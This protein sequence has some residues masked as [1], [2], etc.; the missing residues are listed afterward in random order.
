MKKIGYLI[1]AFLLLFLNSEAVYASNCSYVEQ[2]NLN[3]IAGKVD[4]KYEVKEE[5]S[6]PSE[7]L[8]NVS[9]PNT[10]LELVILNITP[11]VYLNISNDYPDYEAKITDKVI[12]YSDSSEGIYRMRWDN[13]NRI[14]KFTIVIYSSNSTNCPDEKITTKTFVMPKENE[15]YRF[16]ICAG[17]ANKYCQQ[18]I[19]FE[20]PEESVVAKAI[21]E[22][23]GYDIPGEESTEPVSQTTTNLLIPIVIGSVFAF[24]LIVIVIVIVVK[25]KKSYDRRV[26]KNDF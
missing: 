24:I 17:S 7:S 10:Y 6:D 3:K 21:A 13:F 18:F 11:E 22:E 20:E 12:S 9:L 23:Q 8:D 14:T 1:G 4:I 16:S 2:S 19:T 25:K 15:Y 5:M 26:R